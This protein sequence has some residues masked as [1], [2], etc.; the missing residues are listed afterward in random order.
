MN[1]GE[2]TTDSF[3]QVIATWFEPLNCEQVT[4]Q[5]RQCR[6]SAH[7]K[8]DLHGC[9]QVLLCKQ[10]LNAWTRKAH[11]RMAPSCLKCGRAWPTTSDAFRVVAI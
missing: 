11:T 1:S 4:E 5:G 10:H 8:L 6:R 7:W 2:T 3:Q 9:Q